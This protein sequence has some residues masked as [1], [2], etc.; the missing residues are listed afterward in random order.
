MSTQAKLV[1]RQKLYTLPVVTNWKSAPWISQRSAPPPATS[2]STSYSN[3]GTCR[4]KVTFIDG[5]QGILRYRGIH[6]TARGEIL[7]RRGIS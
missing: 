1:G 2:R 7:L 5:E 3:T 6:R 4:N